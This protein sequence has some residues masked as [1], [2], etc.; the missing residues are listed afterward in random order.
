[1]SV[2]EVSSYA[3]EV[4]A[5][6]VSSVGLSVENENILFLDTNRWTNQ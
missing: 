5:G 6:K 1:M 3:K 4:N 2:R